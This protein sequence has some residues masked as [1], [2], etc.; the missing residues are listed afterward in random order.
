M[1]SSVCEDEFG[2]GFDEGMLRHCLPSN[3]LHEACLHKV[4]NT[5]YC[6]Q[7][8]HQLRFHKSS[9]SVEPQYSRSSSHQR[10]KLANGGYGMQAIFL[11]SGQRS[12]GTGV[13]L[14]QTGGTNFQTRK[15]KPGCAPVLLP[16]RVIRA[17]N[18]NVHT[19]SLQISRRQDPKYE[20]RCGEDISKPSKKKHDQKNGSKQDDGVDQSHIPEKIFLPKEWTY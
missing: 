7:N 1:A 4:H 19:L 12:C 18:L 8:H 11:E 14:P 15:K 20:P 5:R 6:L 17:L 9:S 10:A 2:F 16:D 13:F 3:V